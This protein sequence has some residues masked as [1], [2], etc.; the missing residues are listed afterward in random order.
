MRLILTLALALGGAALAGGLALA[1]FREPAREKAAG[2]ATTTMRMTMHRARAR[3]L[4]R[5][6]PIARG[7][8]AAPLQ[9]SAAASLGADRAVLLGG[10]TAAD[11]STADVRLVSGGRDRLVARLP[12]ALHDASAA[13]LADAAY[14]FGG[15]D[16]VAQHDEI[17]RIDPVTWQPRVVGRLPAPSSD[18]STAV[19]GDTAYVVGGYTG[20]RWLDTVVAWKPGAPARVVA[21][22]PRPVRYAAVTAVGGHARRRRRV[23]PGRDGQ[24]CRLALRAGARARAPHR[25]S[26]GADDPR[27][28][29]DARR[30]RTT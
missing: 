30:R 17:V 23:A 10:L 1:L 3:G 26:A 29:R 2:N 22:L 19:I 16:G 15:G 18:H 28:G 11:T 13:R 14:L 5:V 25:P 8:L 4:L 27:G 7:H 9:D 24:R 12:R 20:A 6:V 21:H